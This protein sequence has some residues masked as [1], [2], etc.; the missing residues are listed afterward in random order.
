MTSDPANAGPLETPPVVAIVGRPNVGKSALFN[1]LTRRRIAIVDP[2]FGVTRDRVTALVEWEDRLVELMDTGGMGG[3][4]DLSDEVDRQIE[5]AMRCADL[6]VFVVDAQAGRCPGDAFVAKRLRRL[7]EH[8]ILVAN[9][10]DHPKH[11]VNVA[12]FFALGFGEPL[13]CS[14]VQGNGREELM[15]RILEATPEVAGKETEPELLLAVVGRQNVGKSTLINT[16]AREER[17]IVSE[18]PGTT[19]DSVDVRF[20]LDGR[21]F[22]AIDTAGLKRRQKAKDSVEF[23]SFAR[24]DGAIRRADVVLLMVDVS[25][26]IARQDMRIAHR[27][28]ELGKPCAIVVNKWDLAE[29]FTQEDYMVYLADHLPMLS[30]A[31]VSFMS[32]RDGLNVRETI[33]LSNE[34]YEQSNL[35]VS[36]SRFNEL[37]KEAQERR[38]PPRRGN[39]QPKILYGTQLAGGPPTFL[40][41]ASDPRLIDAN[42]TR[43]LTSFLREG[44]G[45]LEVPIRV[46]YR[47][48]RAAKDEEAREERRAARP[49]KPPQ[50]SRQPRPRG[51]RR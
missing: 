19:R 4:G 33:D 16:L 24:T 1:A 18:I 17:V 38:M 31:P 41:F 42:Y 9:K 32:A 2:T 51:R 35:R 6:I 23:Y 43:Y 48:R 11:G 36:T 29:T 8:V 14:A 49:P 26:D 27:I 28:E 40:L 7:N 39:H 45:P 13:L 30:Y 37:L 5:T 22:V 21:S 46:L 10:V 3:E 34:L 50:R 44:L 47:S 15:E 25:A 20:E 12:D